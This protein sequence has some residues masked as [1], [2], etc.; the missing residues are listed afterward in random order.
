MESPGTL[1]PLSQAAVDETVTLAPYDT[2]WPRAFEV[3][4]NR[5]CDALELPRDSIEHIGSTAV[6]GLVAKPVVD[7]M[8]GVPRY[9][10]LDT[11]VSRLVI[12]GYADCG[13]AGVAG[14]RY[15]RVR[16]GQSFNLHIIQRD[17]PH[18]TNNLRLR[19][20]LRIDAMARARYVTAKRKALADG[21][22][23]LAYSAAKQPALTTL[24]AEAVSV[25]DA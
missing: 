6:P 2:L 23:L 9:P 19:D 7:M 15:L 10:P 24:L 4:R 13:E 1:N 8:L 14:R 3:E 17:G 25:K 12:L 16:E 5:I 21:D 18:W 20:Y 22:R 11:T